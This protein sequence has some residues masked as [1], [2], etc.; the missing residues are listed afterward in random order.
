MSTFGLRA[1]PCSSCPYRCDV[2]SG[3]WAESE[4]DK[5]PGYDGDT[6]QQIIAGATGLFCCHQT[7]DFLCAGWVGCH[8]MRHAAAVRLHWREIGNMGALLNYVSPVPLF[9][10]GAEAALHGMR[11]L[12]HPSSEARAKID[13]LLRIVARRK[14]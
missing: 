12:A 10:S 4:Y 14:S 2:P 6:G 11:D 7:P 13:Q 8:D 1:K 9:S 3:I 5:L